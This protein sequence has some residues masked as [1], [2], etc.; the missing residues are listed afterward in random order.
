MS[1]AP[2]RVVIAGGG[3]AGLEA[4]L[5][6]HAQLAGAVELTLVAPQEDF[7]YRPLAVAVP[8]TDEPIPRLA[9]ADVA[10][11][12][13]AAFVRASLTAVDAA[14]RT[15]VLGDGTRL[16]YD[17]LVVA[18]GAHAEPV[19]PGAIPLGGPADAPA[20][21]A[22]VAQV[23]AGQARRVALTVPDGVAWTLPLYDLALQLAAERGPGG[24]PPELVL[25]TT[26]AEPLAA[27]G[28]EVA[29]EVRELLE[30]GGVRLY[31][32]GTVEAFDDGTL[33]IDFEG[34]A[35]VDALIALPRLRGPAIEGL[36]HDA[37][38][39]LP[40]D[41]MARVVGVEHVYAAGDAC[42]F[43]LKQGGIAAQEADVAAAHIAWTAGAG[44]QP[45]P[46]E[47]VLR[48]ELLTG[49]VPRFLRARVPQRGEEHDAGQVSQEPLWW[50]PA[51]IAARELAPYLAGRLLP[52]ADAAADA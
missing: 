33:W 46:L 24:V 6:L 31:T 16:P 51:K 52:A 25:V 11:E 40:I 10:A 29:A 14:A 15:A 26:E 34:G 21:A 20:L 36:P 8:F 41:R 19:T 49:A 27:F 17:A 37:E 7:V 50:P 28:P 45:A 48:G 32:A 44:P 42:A 3:V 35:E 12:H 23:R 18:V 1:T 9:L 39:F 2:T 5:A 4:L 22:L 43:S 30:S 47:L 13:G 38:G